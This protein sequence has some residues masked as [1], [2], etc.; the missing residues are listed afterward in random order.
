LEALVQTYLVNIELNE[1]TNWP[2]LCIYGLV[3]QWQ[4]SS[5]G[6]V[7]MELTVQGML[8]AA[9]NILIKHRFISYQARSGMSRLH[10]KVSRVAASDSLGC[11]S[12]VCQNFNDM[13]AKLQLCHEPMAHILTLVLNIS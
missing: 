4:P 8:A 6:Q 12:E 2:G 9:F 1:V 5:N 7:D 3:A 13:A 11:G 10:L